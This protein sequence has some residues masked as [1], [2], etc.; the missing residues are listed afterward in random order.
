MGIYFKGIQLDGN[1]D[2]TTAH[3]LYYDLAQKPVILENK[4]N[5]QLFIY[6]S[7]NNLACDYHNKAR[8]FRNFN[9]EDW[10]INYV[11]S[12]Y[13]K[14]LE[15]LLGECALLSERIYGSK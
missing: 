5:S 13:N 15:K 3:G 14:E 4:K 10:R 9:P 7:S 12:L 6:T 2:E 8:V 11:P 1:Q